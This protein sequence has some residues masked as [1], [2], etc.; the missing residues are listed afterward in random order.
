MLKARAKRANAVFSEREK[1]TSCVQPMR[2]EFAQER[3][4]QG[5][6]H[7]SSPCVLRHEDGK[8]HAAVPDEEAV[9]GPQRLLGDRDEPGHLRIPRA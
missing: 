5:A 2:R 9:D 1:A 6:G 3:H 4:Q 7:A 8:F